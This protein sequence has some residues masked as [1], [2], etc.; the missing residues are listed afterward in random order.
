MRELVVGLLLA[1]LVAACSEAPAPSLRGRWEAE[2]LKIQS[3]ALPSGPEFEVQETSVFLP[4]GNISLPFNSLEQKKGQATL[5]FPLGLGWT[6]FFEGPDR[7]YADVP[8][9]GKVYYKRSTSGLL[10]AGNTAKPQP[11]PSIPVPVP[12]AQP[13]PPSQAAVAPSPQAHPGSELLR[14]AG[15]LIADRQFGEA[16]ATLQQAELSGAPRGDLLLEMAALSSARDNQD[17]AV[18]QVSAAL[19][20]GL[21]FSR[22]QSDSRLEQVR[23][24][25]RYRAL[26]GRFSNAP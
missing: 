3:L 20:A 24:D 23:D 5:R 10:S 22:V 9:L 18:R 21:P 15:T 13:V 14:K 12:T 1:C 6:F 25:V 2:D 11:G 16:E 26:A 7:I 4:G 17:D 8:F 19:S